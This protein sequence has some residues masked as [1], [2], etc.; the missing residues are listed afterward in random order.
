MRLAFF[1]LLLSVNGLFAQTRLQGFV[2]DAVTGETLDGVLVKCRSA[3]TVTSGGGAY[4]L[5]LP[6]GKFVVIASLDGYSS[7]TQQIEITDGLKELHFHIVNQSA[8]MQAV[9]I[10]A[11]VAKDR[12]TPIAYSN[13]SGKAIGERLGSGDMPMLL[14][15]TPGVY[16]TQQGGGSGDARITIRGF[17]QRNIA[18]MIDGIPV[19]DMEN[20]E[21]YWSNWFGLG[22]VTALTQVQRGLGSSRIANPAVGGTINIITRGVNDKFKASVS[23]EM[24]DSRYRKFSA[25]INS[26][27]LPGDM[28]FVLSFTSR[29]SDGYVDYLFD[30]MYAYFAKFEK[31]WG[32]NHTLSFTAIGA[33]QSHGQRSFRARLPL[34][35]TKLAEKLGLDTAL[36]GMPQNQGRK[37]NQH[38]GYLQEANVENGDTGWVGE[39]YALNERVNEFHKPQLYLKHDWKINGKALLSSTVYTSSGRGGGTAADKVNQV[40]GVYGQFNFQGSYFSH[41]VATPFYSPI[42]PMYS[43]T[44]RKST[45]IL[46]RNVNNHNWYGLLSTLNYKYNK[47]LTINAGIDLRTYKGLHYRE[48]HN[49]LGGDYYV[50]GNGY[51]DP[52]REDPKYYKGDKFRFNNDGLVRWTGA[53]AEVEYTQRRTTVFGNVSVSNSWYRRI[54][55]FKIS[56]DGSDSTTPWVTRAGATVKAGVNHNISRSFNVFGNVGY[57]NRPTRFNNVFDNANREIKNAEN[58]KVYAIE[59]GAGYKSRQISVDLNAYYTV[60]Q[61]RPMNSLPTFRD[62]EGNVFSYNINGLGARHIGAEIAAAYKPGYGITAEM[63]VSMGDWIWRNGTRAVVRDDA[64]DSVGFVDFDATGVHVGDA[65]QQQ[66]AASLRWEPLFLKGFYISS[67]FVFFDK[68]FADFDPSSLKG[69]FKQRESFQV[70]SYWY[71]NASAGYSF[72]ATGGVQFTVFANASNITNNL[73]ISDAQHRSVSDDPAPTFNPKNLEVFVSPGFRY[74][75]GVRASF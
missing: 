32:K 74:T 44:L 19:N 73:Y 56:P 70:P 35:D 46:Y 10:T 65:A 11:S 33:P 38:W 13:I 60:W 49:L 31:Q 71:L 8:S 9:E 24:G 64:G 27:K 4:K 42:D 62:V 43:N 25:T 61:N 37:Y 22:E 1:F 6:A 14:N 53:F 69:A 41:T 63:A 75:T 52:R 5:L 45:G 3:E 67:Q 34:Y 23:A 66:V 57:L 21:V 55:H 12:K 29:Q 17:N 36:A 54:D 72:K 30:N 18:V 2:Y 26:G 40:P 47:N 50:P 28:G 59:G 48:V 15:S 58:E 20:G 16:A 51:N 7:D 68:H 39:R